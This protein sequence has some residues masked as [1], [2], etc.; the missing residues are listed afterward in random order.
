[1]HRPPLLSSAEVAV[2]QNM[3][4]SVLGRTQ[5]ALLAHLVPPS[6]R[7]SSEPTTQPPRELAQGG[8]APS[9]IHRGLAAALHHVATGKDTPLSA[10]A[11]A[12]LVRSGVCDPVTL[13]R[14]LAIHQPSGGE[15][16]LWRGAQDARVQDTVL[17]AMRAVFGG[18][19][20]PGAETGGSRHL[21]HTWH[22]SA[23]ETGGSRHLNRRCAHVALKCMGLASGDHDSLALVMTWRQ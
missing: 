9:T 8:A 22:S 6:P 12:A 10:L 23:G 14:L 2:V 17:R 18:A 21:N 4:F 15:K 16:E 1:M 13:R 11:E 3:C 7:H 20:V 5:D 19:G